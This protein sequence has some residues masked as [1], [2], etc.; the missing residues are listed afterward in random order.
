MASTRLKISLRVAIGKVKKFSEVVPFAW[1]KPLFELE[2]HIVAA[3]DPF[4]PIVYYSKDKRTK[5]IYI[6]CS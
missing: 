1:E 4:S 6:C 2:S 3:G 5:R